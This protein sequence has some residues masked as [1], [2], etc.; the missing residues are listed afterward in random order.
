MIDFHTH[1]LPNIDDGARNID[2]T[3]NLL[4][5][6]KQAGFEAIIATSRYM[7]NYY[8]TDTP[9]KEVL[10]NLIYQHL[11]KYNLGIKIYLGNEIYLS[12][13]IIKLLEEGKASTINDTSYVL[14]ELPI[15]TE[16]ENLYEMINEMRKCKLVPVLAHPEKY[17][18]IQKEPELL[19]NLISEGVLMQVNYGSIV[20]ESGKKAQLL[21]E[22]MYENNMVHLL[23]TDVQRSSTIYN[24]IPEIL[25]ILENYIGEEKLEQLTTINPKLV[26]KNKRIF[27]TEP[28]S[29][30]MSLKEKIIMRLGFIK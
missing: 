25:E 9:E 11:K 8:E 17:T 12:S 13:N 14:F 2:E 26:L 27:V 24:Q 22:K 18:F 15:N 1:V 6:A 10:I 16:P 29:I 19:Y 30:E 3:F 20:G 7:E 4:V 28:T 5:E 23:G 21:V